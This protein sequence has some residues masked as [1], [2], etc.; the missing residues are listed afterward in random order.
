M[1][2]PCRL[3]TDK[4]RSTRGRRYGHAPVESGPPLGEDA[5]HHVLFVGCITEGTYL[6]ASTTFIP[7]TGTSK[8][9]LIGCN[10]AQFGATPDRI[11]MNV[12]PM[13]AETSEA[14]PRPT[15]AL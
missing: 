11:F 15:A 13:I 12:Q 14:G 3:T 8:G 6:P 7:R 4:S 10:S 5:I 9:A 1:R 2:L